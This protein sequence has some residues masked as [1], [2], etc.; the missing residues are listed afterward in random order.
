VPSEP[1]PLTIVPASP[2]AFLS[3]F[4]NGV[5][6]VTGAACAATQCAVQSGGAYQLWGNGFGPKNGGSQDGAPAVYT[7]TLSPLEVSGG[8]SACQLMIAGRPTIVQYCGAAP[9]EIIDQLNFVYPSGVPATAYVD[10]S[11]T[12]SGVTGWFRVP[13]PSDSGN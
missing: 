7:G 5:A 8:A 11:L 9:G 13:A 4:T 6:W 10:A 2:A 1:A 12:I 3:E